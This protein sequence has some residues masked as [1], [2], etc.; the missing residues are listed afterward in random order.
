MNLGKILCKKQLK[1]GVATYKVLTFEIKKSDTNSLNNDL[2]ER[3]QQDVKRARTYAEDFEFKLSF[4]NA[5][6]KYEQVESM[7]LEDSDF[8]ERKLA[9][10]LYGTN[11]IYFYDFKKNLV[12][13]N[14][15]FQGVNST[16]IHS[17]TSLQW[18][19]SNES[20]DI[21]GITC[22]KAIRNDSIQT[23]KKGI[24]VKKVI[25]WY[26]PEINLPI[27]PKGNCG[28]PGLIV[29]LEENEGSKITYLSHIK[30]TKK[31]Q[32]IALPST[33]NAI[34]KKEYDTKIK[35]QIEAF[36]ESFK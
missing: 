27:G 1:N 22:Y 24:I 25:A 17:N 36:R 6:A 10:I 20:M 14:K 18:A 32:K 15:S 5:L 11:S 4:T 13:E 35:K 21:D 26:N 16:I 30:F 9:K 8:M 34:T 28:L 19:L 12:L 31:E 7:D 2:K 3:I 33:E 29:R 23:R